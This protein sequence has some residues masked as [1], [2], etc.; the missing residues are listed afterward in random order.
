MRSAADMEDVG[1]PD[2]GAAAART[3]STRSCWASACQRSC[4]VMKPILTRASQLQRY[5]W[6]WKSE[7]TEGTRHGYIAATSPRRPRPERLDRLPLS[8]LAAKR[9]SRAQEAGR[10]GRRGHVQSD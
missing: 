1:W 10:R 9:R 3:E 7:P 2:L 4:S 8:R 6:V 5:P